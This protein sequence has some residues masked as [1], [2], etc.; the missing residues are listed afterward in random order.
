MAAGNTL[1]F[2]FSQ[3]LDDRFITTDSLM[4]RALPMIE[5][6]MGAQRVFFFNWNAGNSIISQRMMC[7][8]GNNYYLQED[9]YVDPGAP[10]I[11]KFLHDGV[12]DAPALEY[13]AVYVLLVWRT[14]LN[15]IQTLQSRQA[16]RSQ[17]GV[18]RVERFKVNKPFAREDKELL[19][20]L[21]RELC[22]KLNMAE[23]DH[24]NTAQLKRAV[25]LNDLAQVFA[26]SIRLSDSL[27]EILKSVQSSFCFDRTSL[28]LA[29]PQ[30]GKMQGLSV[31]I[32]GDIKK[33]DE[34]DGLLGRFCGACTQEFGQCPAFGISDIS[35]T[36]PLR[37][38]NKN[39]GCLV[40]DNVLSRSPISQEDVL[41]LRQ[42]S[43]Q[44]ALAI[45]NARLFEKVQELS[46]YDDLT[47]LTLRRFFNE[48][49]AQEI[50]RSRRFNLTFSLLLMDIDYFKSINDEYGHV[51]GDEALKA[52]SEV[53]RSSL[54]Q[55]D[56]PCRFGGDEIMILFPRTTGEEALSI[57][58]RLAAK[59]SAVKLPDR[60]TRGADIKLSVSQ[61]IAVFPYDG[62]DQTDLVRRADDA[63]YYVKE[64]GRGLCKLYGEIAEDK[65]A[66]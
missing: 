59:V 34:Q 37:L 66:E 29:D 60:L 41:S 9:I 38:Q 3:N 24:Y 39:L 33:V 63:L 15:S 30:T 49:F 54:R 18:L 4:E 50:Y 11:I 5:H 19:L 21:A 31:D 58:K 16:T 27:E 28:Y 52:V 23:I 6:Y 7:E 1:L 61:G 22:V 56:I 2:E 32:A 40:F 13:P 42:F 48:T 64:H 45:D 25:A 46:N 17:Y 47:K 8:S 55:T 65:K 10:E 12:M 57:A 44:I 35:I 51:L 36:L 14:P 62:D 20:G 53:I 26:T 43:A